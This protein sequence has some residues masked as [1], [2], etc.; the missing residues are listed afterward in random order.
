MH[1]ALQA[2]YGLLKLSISELL[3][4]DTFDKN[5]WVGSNIPIIWTGNN[6][7]SKKTGFIEILLKISVLWYWGEPKRE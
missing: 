3:R 7:Y 2:V 1:V 5:G 4:E 6:K